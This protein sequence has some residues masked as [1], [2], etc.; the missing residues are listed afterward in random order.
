[1]ADLVDMAVADKGL[2]AAVA[3]LTPSRSER[4]INSVLSQAVA[5]RL[6]L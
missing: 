6:K 3:K 1:M 4:G 5:G 2:D